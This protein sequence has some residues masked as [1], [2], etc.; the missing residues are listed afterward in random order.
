[1]KTGTFC[2]ARLCLMGTLLG[3]FHTSTALASVVSNNN[4]VDAHVLPGTSSGTTTGTNLASNLEVDEPTHIGDGTTS[5]WWRWTAPS[6]GVVSFDTE[7]S[8]FD[9]VLEVYT[10]AAIDTLT[11][12]AANDDAGGDAGE[13]PSRLSFVAVS[14]TTYHIA[15][16]GFESATGNIVLNWEPKVYKIGPIS[17][18]NRVG[19]T[20]EFYYGSEDTTPTP[21]FFTGAP[22]YPWGVYVILD[23]DSDRAAYVDY[24]TEKV[25]TV[26]HKYYEVSLSDY[27]GNFP[28]QIIPLRLPNQWQ[29]IYYDGDHATYQ[30]AASP[31]Y[32]GEGNVQGETRATLG[33]ATPLVLSP[34]L[35]INVPRTLTGAELYNGHFLYSQDDD[36]MNLGYTGRMFQRNTHKWTD[37]LD[38]LKTKAANLTDLTVGGIVYP[39]G[40]LE[41]GTLLMVEMLK[42]KGYTEAD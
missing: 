23:P 21:T 7:G 4:F 6:T 24:W 9:T 32:L 40:S 29:W 8:D 38:I 10:G 18:F 20:T 27:E 37:T 17:I 15:V 1:M 42:G 39:K 22:V 16:T 31:P 19:S 41:N 2:F 33:K 14:G 25:G 13:G 3:L 12:V 35:T 26:T 11:F 30:N 5:V 34:T 36:G 28:Y